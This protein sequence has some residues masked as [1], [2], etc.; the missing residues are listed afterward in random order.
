MGSIN[1]QLFAQKVSE[2]LRKGKKVNKGKLAL[3]SGYSLEVSKK[4]HMITKTKSYQVAF[5]LENKEI[6]D[7]IDRDIARIQQAIAS[8]NLKKEE[9]KTLVTSLDTFIKNKQLLSGGAT[10]NVGLS[11]AISEK[12]ANKYADVSND[13]AKSSSSDTDNGST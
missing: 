7:K 11:I 6:V 4:P 12:I 5:A 1:A 13:T 10:A 3:E 2:T 8:K 9:L